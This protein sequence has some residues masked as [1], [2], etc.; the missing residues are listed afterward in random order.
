VRRIPGCHPGTDDAVTASGMCAQ[1]A[2]FNASAIMP[3]K[4][5]RAEGEGRL[6]GQ[7]PAG[8]RRL[9]GQRAASQEQPS[10]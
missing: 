10:V 7:L 3:L 4:P 5:P 6:E 8:R 2:E 1:Q 9:T